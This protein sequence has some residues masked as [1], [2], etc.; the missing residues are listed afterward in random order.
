VYS[1]LLLIIVEKD[2]K[3]CKSN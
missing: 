2:F 1:S 3:I